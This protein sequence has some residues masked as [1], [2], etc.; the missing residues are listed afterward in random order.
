MEALGNK[1]KTRFDEV[2]DAGYERALAG[3]KSSRG[4]ADGQ[5]SRSAK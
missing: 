3:S 2:V 1:M 5:R 4:S